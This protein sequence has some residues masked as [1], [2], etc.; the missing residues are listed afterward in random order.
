MKLLKVGICFLDEDDN[1]MSKRV[2]GTD[3]ALDYDGDRKNEQ[4]IKRKYNININDELAAV[5]TE[6]IKLQL[7]EED[8]K[9]MLVEVR[10]DIN[11]E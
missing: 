9:Q 7:K 5:L 6:N 4:E 8:I 3:W 2:V 11:S 1:V 10:G